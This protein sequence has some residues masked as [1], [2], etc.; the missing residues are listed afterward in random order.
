MNLRRFA[1]LAAF[2]LAA[3]LPVPTPAGPSEDAN[4]AYKNGD[5]ATALRLRRDLAEQGDPVAQRDLGKM[6]ADGRGVAKDDVSA[7]QWYRKSAEQG[8]AGGQVSLGYMYETGRGVAKDEVEAVEWYRKAAERGDAVGQANLGYMH[9]TGRGVAKDEVE[10]VQWYRRAAEQGF[11]RAQD[12]LGA[13]YRDGRGV[14]RDDAAAAGWFRKSAEQGH[15]RA[16][17]NL[18]YM[19]ETGRG[20]AKDDTQAVEWYRKSAGQGNARAQAN[21]GSM[22]FNGRG[23]LPRDDKQAVE[24]YRNAAEQGLALGQNNLGVMYRDGRGVVQDSA[25]AVRW[26]RKAAEQGY[27]TAQTN[28]GVMFRDGRGVSEDQAEAVRWLRKA[29]E[30]KDARAQG[31]LDSIEK[32]SADA[33]AATRPTAPTQPVRRGITRLAGEDPVYPRE[34]IRMGIDNGKV[35]ARVMIDEKGDVDN[36]VIVKAEPSE[37]FD[38]A[39]IDALRTWKFTADGEKYVG[40]IEVKF[41]LQTVTE[42]S[43]KKAATLPDS[44]ERGTPVATSSPAPLPRA[45]TGRNTDFNLGRVRLRT[46]GGAWESIGVG[47]SGLPFSGDISGQMQFETQHLLLRADADGKFQAALAVSASQGG[48]TGHFTWNSNCQPRP[49][50]HAIDNTHGNVDALDCLR[51]TGLVSTQ[52]A[53]QL[54]A[55]GLLAD[56]ASRK[57]A[58]PRAAYAV[59]DEAGLPNGTFVTVLVVFA[60]DFNLPHAASDQERLPDSVRPEA[61]AWGVR[62]ADA[63]RSSIHSLSGTLVLPAVAVN[64][65]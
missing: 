18:G 17:A 48:G 37:Y 61:V 49:N 3:S 29:A 13:M 58:L 65:N 40:E 25:E 22:Y 11:A 50:V 36:V 6:Y 32:R 23:G 15:A 30:Q 12:N 53:L 16:Q 60:A 5:Y 20:V 33:G 35:R 47:R 14:P 57:I 24:L 7:V 27:A 8:F 44:S 26:F 39:V 19:Y 43:G 59:S 45:D 31:I 63:V 2:L 42:Q 4:A 52:E 51:V 34:A 41:S 64:A 55:P 46:P 21:L 38:Q 62:L 9:E 1:R 56:L 10:A 54:M 28:L